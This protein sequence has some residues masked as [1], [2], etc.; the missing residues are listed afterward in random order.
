MGY[1]KSILATIKNIAIGSTI[2][3]N[4]NYV[5]GRTIQVDNDTVI[6][7][8]KDIKINDRK[9][10]IKITGNVESVDTAAGNVSVTG[11]V[12]SASSVSGDVKV[13]GMANGN[14]ET[15]S[16]CIEIGG[17][18]GGSISTTSG[19]V[20][21]KGSVKGKVETLSGDISYRK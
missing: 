12:K 21:V 2:T 15:T 6:I 14:V 19:D 3:I 1:F 4:G 17:D 18:V 16:G 11:D 20:D 9:I 5:G 8:G 7:D 13:G 10:E